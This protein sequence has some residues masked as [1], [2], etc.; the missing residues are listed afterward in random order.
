[1]QR[2]GDFSSLPGITRRFSS[3]RQSLQ[4]FHQPLHGLIRRLKEF[5]QPPKDAN[6]PLVGFHQS[7]HGFI[8]PLRGFIQRLKEFI[9]SLKEANQSLLDAWQSLKDANQPSFTP[10]LPKTANFTGLTQRRKEAKTRAVPK[11]GVRRRVAAF[12][13]RDMSRRFKARTCP[14]SPN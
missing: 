1:M 11:F 7:L 14:R 10:F 3:L 4:D 12:L 5:L 8:Q 6:Q 13:R 9:Q 2:I